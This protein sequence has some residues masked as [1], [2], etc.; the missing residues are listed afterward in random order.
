MKVRR[1]VM[2]GKSVVFGANMRAQ[3]TAH[4]D[5]LGRTWNDVGFRTGVVAIAKVPSAR[6]GADASQQQLPG[7]ECTG[8]AAEV[9]VVQR[10]AQSAVRKLGFEHDAVRIQE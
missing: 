5:Q 2:Q 3:N 6:Y 9:D 7:A 4:I 8:A 10:E 1:S